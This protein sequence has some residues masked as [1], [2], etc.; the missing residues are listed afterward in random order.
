MRPGSYVDKTDIG[1][2]RVPPHTQTGKADFRSGN[3][4]ELL[5]TVAPQYEKLASV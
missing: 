4:H 5:D 2:G 3:G 1:I